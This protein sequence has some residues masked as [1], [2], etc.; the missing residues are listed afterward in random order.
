MN[1]GSLVLES[2]K[3]I[4]DHQNL[5]KR[6]EFEKAPTGQKWDNVNLQTNNDYNGLK[7]IKCVK[8]H[9]LVM[10]VQKK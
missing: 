4:K 9:D 3:A 6:T 5:V 2:K 1:L 10:I 8:I 7:H